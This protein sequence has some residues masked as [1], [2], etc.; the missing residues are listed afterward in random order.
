MS[1]D[2][3]IY[4]FPDECQKFEQRHPLWKECFPN[5]VH[6]LN[7]AFK[8][9]QTMWGAEDKF[10]YLFGRVC[11]EDFMEILLVCFHGYGAA[12][13][14]LIRSMYEHTVTLCYL[15]E[16]PDEVARFMDYHLVQQDKLISR[17]IETFGESVLPAETVKNARRKADEVRDKF[18]VT[19]CKK[20]D[21]KRPSYTWSKLDFVAM[22]KRAGVIGT[23]IVPGY[24]LP[25]RHAHATFGG[26]S[27]RLEIV[28]G[29]MGVSPDAQPELADRSL[30]TAHNCL[31]NVLEVE[32]NRFKM[33]GMEQ[34]LQVCFEDFVR[35]WSP[36]S[37]LLKREP[38][39]G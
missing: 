10:V 18:M 16:Y 34:A 19:D 39:S 21:T 37:P 29:R 36:D 22:A 6:A 23:L 31:L 38:D 33:E 7:L 8:R 26:L 5:L 28:D 35:V 24:F 11:L 15:H 25:L 1:N 13:S 27:E 30:M 3:P 4:G 12:A 32:K 9:E 20:C 2:F 17:I 14:K